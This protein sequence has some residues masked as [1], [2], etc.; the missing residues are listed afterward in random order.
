MNFLG[1]LSINDNDIVRA[2]DVNKFADLIVESLRNISIT[3]WVYKQIIENRIYNSSYCLFFITHNILG[4]EKFLEAQHELE[5]ENNANKRQLSFDFVADL[6]RRSILD[7]IE[8]EKSYDNIALYELGIKYGFLPK[9]INQELRKL[10]LANKIEIS[11]LPDKKR[12]R[13]GFYINYDHHTR[14]DRIISVTF[15]R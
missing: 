15:K 11:E 14:G 3:Q 4:A 13:K 2:D 12:Q 1:A 10:E 8:F 6:N 5:K 9:E 7:V